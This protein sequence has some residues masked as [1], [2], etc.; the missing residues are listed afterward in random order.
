MP[1]I[2]QL[3][4]RH[5]REHEAHLKHIDE[6]MEQASKAEQAA[7]DSSEVSAEL[8]DLKQERGKLANQLDELRQKSAEEWAQ[9]GGPMIIWDIVAGRLE[10]LVERI[11]H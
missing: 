11:K 7:A 5:I 6:L 10:K 1:D 4:E 9:K 3:A 8:A 2:N